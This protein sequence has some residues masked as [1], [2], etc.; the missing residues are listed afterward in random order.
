M[1]EQL[2]LSRLRLSGSKVIY[3]YYGPSPDGSKVRTGEVNFFNCLPILYE[4]ISAVMKQSVSPDQIFDIKEEIISSTFNSTV[5]RHV[6]SI[7]Y[8]SPDGLIIIEDDEINAFWGDE[9]VSDVV[10]PAEQL[11]N[12]T[13]LNIAKRRAGYVAV[14]RLCENG[15]L[16]A[17]NEPTQNALDNCHEKCPAFA[18]TD[19]FKLKHRYAKNP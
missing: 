15:L 19:S 5:R 8:P 7:L 10:L 1:A 17:C 12:M 11:S 4:Y 14:V 13:A 16:N 9:S 2:R 6:V 18:V 3:P